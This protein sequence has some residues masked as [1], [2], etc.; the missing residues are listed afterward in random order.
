MKNN[1]FMLKDGT[2]ITILNIIQTRTEEVCRI[3]GHKCNVADDNLYEKP[4]QSSF[5]K[6][7]IDSNE[8]RLCHWPV[9][10]MCKMWSI[11]S[12]AVRVLEYSGSLKSEP[13]RDSVSKPSRVPEGTERLG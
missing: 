2:I 12:R 4:C 9:S 7:F 11:R 6:V 10:Q 13:I 5:V 8:T 3:I 1:C